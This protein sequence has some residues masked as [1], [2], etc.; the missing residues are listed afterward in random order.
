[1]FDFE[2]PFAVAAEAAENEPDLTEELDV[3]N[4][5][6]D[7]I[8]D[9]HATQEDLSGRADARQSTEKASARI[10]EKI[11]KRRRERT[12]IT[13]ARFAVIAVLLGF[14]AYLVAQNGVDWLGWTLGIGAGI[15]G[16]I[17]AYGVGK[18]HE[19]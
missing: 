8:T 14:L 3:E 2:N 12:G 6:W 15:C 13:A 10:Y 9:L 19:M 16:L 17:A 4:A 5:E 18:Y 11:S 1:M 7:A